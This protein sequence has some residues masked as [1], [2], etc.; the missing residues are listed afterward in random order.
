MVGAL[1]IE[2]S[3][4]GDGAHAGGEA[5]SERCKPAS[6]SWLSVKAWDQLMSY[7]ASLGDAFAGLPDAI[8]SAPD[9][10]KVRTY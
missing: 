9:A 7:E 8:E 2:S 4:D 6:L 3:G 10:W 1:V 5:E